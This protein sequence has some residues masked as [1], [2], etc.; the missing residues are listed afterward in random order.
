MSRIAPFSRLDKEKICLPNSY[1]NSR[2]RQ[3]AMTKIDSIANPNKSKTR[4]VMTN[5]QHPTHKKSHFLG[6]KYFSRD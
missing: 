6:D 1:L 5:A 3:Y 4:F 2:A